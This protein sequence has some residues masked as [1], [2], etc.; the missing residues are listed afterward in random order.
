MKT[1][2]VLGPHPELAE[3]LRAAL[4]PERYRLIHRT[5]L[6]E[7]EPFL[8][9][10][11]A[12]ACVIDGELT[13]VRALWMV[14]KVRRRM[15]HWPLLI[16]TGSHS[17]EWEEEAYLQGVSHVL[18]KPVRP[19]LVNTLLDRL[20]A[21]ID[22][23]GAS[24]TSA[25]APA[26]PRNVPDQTTP[27]RALQILRDFSAI[28]THS[29]RAEGLLRQ[30]LLLLREIIGVNRATI[31]LRQPTSAFGTVPSPEENRRLRS[32]CAIGLSHGLLEH[33]ELSFESGIGG[34]LFRHG[35]ILRRDG[36]EA[37]RDREIQKEFEILGA[38]VAIPILDRETLVG[39]AAFDGRVTGDPLMNGELELIFHLL[40][41]L[42]LA[43]KN[44]WL[45]DQ[46]ANNHEMMVDILRQLSS[47]CVVVSR[48]LVILH[49]NRMARTYF[50]RPGRRGTDLEF[51]DLPQVLGSRVYQVLKTG[52]AVAPFRYQ[53]D[54]AHDT[55]YLVTIVPFQKQA[56]ALPSSALL[57]VEDQ[58]KTEQLKRLEIET[59]NLRLIKT[60][61]DR[62]THEIGNALVPLSTHQQLLA[63]KYRDPE[64]RASL[65]TA[66]ADGV[67]RISRLNSQMRFLAKDDILSKDAFP[68]AQLVEEAHQ[69]AQR[70][71]PGKA[72]KFKCED[73]HQP[74]IMAGDR[75]ALKH[76]LAE[77]MLNALQANPADAKVAVKL[78]A[79][80]DTQ[81]T[82][83]VHID[84]HD[85]GTGFAADIVK[86]LPEPFF[87][88]RNVGL[89]LGLTV[90]RKIIETHHGRL[91]ILETDNGASGTVRI[92]LPLEA[93]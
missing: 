77:V 79:E 17:W 93:A 58:T 15:P 51:N 6:E 30:F 70:H 22:T 4:P 57:I 14:E 7:A 78:R 25:H 44:I 3:A 32:A 82:R 19:R 64:F 87:T 8:N 88:T 66:L 52:A 83:W 10:G 26:S 27:T 11:I 40:E 5:N 39:V 86:K 74:I 69:E 84:V 18:S 43:V 92:S 36:E 67:K 33:F 68:L 13:E 42:G 72:A 12:D 60:M 21:R 75:P 71:H 80:T 81:G 1:L 89:G 20:W 28:L 65:D 41:E 76:A 54:D 50:A 29:L 34:Y 31:F 35:R 73:D 91:T 24:P 61:A 16:F 90:S 63:E 37:M 59:A 55:A 48:D 49:A 85:S 47:A 46:V 53:P 62:L 9:S 56:S 2:L 38:Q 23:Q 45:H